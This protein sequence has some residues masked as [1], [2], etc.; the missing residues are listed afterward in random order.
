MGSGPESAR[1][2]GAMSR[3]SRRVAAIAESA[4]LAVDAKAKALQAA[5]EDVIGFGAGEP[6]F[7]TPAHIVEA[8]VAACRDPRNHQYTPTPGLPEL[9]EAI[10]AKTAR[11]SG[12]R[13]RRRPGPRHQRRQARRLQ[14]VPGAARPRRR[15]APP[16]ALLDHVPRG[17]R[18]SPAACRS[19]CSTAEAAGFRV[20]VDQLEAARTPRTKVA[21]V[22]VAE[23]PD[24]RGV[25][26]RRGRGDRAVGRRARRSGSSPTRSTSTS[27]TAVTSSRRCRCSSPSSPTRASCST[28]SPRR[29]R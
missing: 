26:A 16:R 1:D 18:R 6:D 15:G 25:P 13:V 4:T 28:A 29:T 19:R 14:H 27:P 3:I 21:A 9:R 17:D 10:A 20:T 12:Y 24:R 22:R 23:Q 11:D 2:H 5:G 8:A 7:P